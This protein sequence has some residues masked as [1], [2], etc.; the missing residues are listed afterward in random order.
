MNTF[1]PTSA[2]ESGDEV[3]LDALFFRLRRRW[4]LFVGGLLVALALAYV[5]LQL[6]TPVYGFRAT[7]LLGDKGSN[8]RRAQQ[9]LRMLDASTEKGPTMEDE[10]GQLSATGTMR[11]AM[12]RL[13]YAVSYYAVPATWLN[14]LRPLQVRQQAAANVPFRVGINLKAPQLTGVRLWV[15]PAGPRRYR[16]HAEAD[17]GQLVRLPQGEVLRDLGALKLDETVAAGDTLQT[18]LLRLTIDQPTHPELAADQARYFFT[19]NSLPNATAGYLDA[20]TVRP[21]DH[22]SRIVELSMKAPVPELATA[23][24]D[25]LMAV[26]TANDLHDKNLAG[27]K[28]VAFLNEKLA[29]LADSRQHTAGALASFRATRGVVDVGAQSTSGI[30]QLSVLEATQSRLLTSRRYYQNLLRLLRANQGLDQLLAPSSVGIESPVLDQLL[31]ELHQLTAKRAELELSASDINPLVKKSDEAIRV[32]KASLVQLLE[33]MSQAAD[34][35]LRDA[36]AQLGSL[37]G[38]LNRLPEDER[39]LAALKGAADFDEKNYTFLEEKRNE[40]AIVLATNVSDKQVLD[41]AQQLGSTPVAPRPLLVLLIAVLA[42]LGAPAAAT[43][44]LDRANRRIQRPEDLAQ[45]SDIPVLGMVAHGT[46]DD[47][48]LRDPKGPIAESFR[49]LRINLQYLAAGADKKVIGITSSVPGEGKTFC[50]LNLAAEL[51]LG[52]HRVVLLE[53]DLRRPTLASYFA[54]SSADAPGLAALL[55]GRAELPEVLRREVAPGLDVVCCGPPPGNPTTL[56]ESPRM[57]ALLEQLRA[58]YDYVVLDTPPMGY[59]AEFF[60]LL[61]YF[62]ASLYIVRQNYTEKHLL[63]QINDL[64]RTQKVRNLHLV[65]NDVEFAKTYGYGYKAQAYAYGQ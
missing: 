46:P 27:Q 55:A 61:R 64:Y 40:A 51:A 53:C 60:V 34:V 8:S 30:Q 57:A 37:R 59:V 22:E 13:P 16:V 49:S 41:A 63:A 44:L 42:G 28:T 4:P 33:N 19:L 62:D 52:Q 15:E 24:L 48:A 32:A 43:M 36:T 47:S 12:S 5:Y 11:Q 10:V 58:E 50:S 26:Y 3:D 6:K 23:F 45:L 29:K 21:V 2:P 35:G 54:G 17:Q 9:L 20:V 39:Q 7:M 38:Q 14:Q 1:P 65:L 18:P 56:L 31:L 25:T